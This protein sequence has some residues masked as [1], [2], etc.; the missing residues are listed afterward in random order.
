MFCYYLYNPKHVLKLLTII[1]RINLFLS[2]TILSTLAFSQ[3]GENDDVKIHYNLTVTDAYHHLAQ[4]DITFKGVMTKSFN[5]KLPNWRTGKYKILDLA[6]NI[7][8]FQAYDARN[9]P[10]KSAKIDKN[11]WKIFVNTPNIVKVSYQVYANQL[12]YRVS[13][14]D[15]THAFVDASGVFMYAPSLRDKSLTVELNVPKSWH[16]IS[17]LKRLGQHI[18][19][20]NNYD[21]LVDSPI[22]SGIHSY[23]SFKIGQQ[24]Y[25]IVIWGDGNYDRKR[26]I[27][28]IKKLHQQAQAI[29]YDFPFKRYVYIFHVGNKLR[30]ATEHINSTIIQTD[31]FAFSPDKKY[32]KIIGTT[33]HEFIHTWNVK[34]YRPAGISPYDYDKENYSDIFWLAEGTTS[35]YDNLINTRAGIYTLEQSLENLAEDI[36]KYQSKPG[37]KIMSLAESSFDT[38][39]DNN[40]NREHNTAVNIYLKGSL[41]SWLLDKEIRRLTNNNKSL[42]DLQLLLYQ[43]YASSPNGY[44][45]YDVLQLLKQITGYDFK[46]FWYDYVNSTKEINFDKLLDF[47]GLKFEKINKKEQQDEKNISLG[48]NIKEENNQLKISLV[49]TDSPAWLA[50][51]AYGDVLVAINTFAVSKENFD[52]I[53][54]SLRVG[55]SYIVHYFHQG[56]LMQ[57]QITPQKAKHIKRKIV[58]QKTANNK[59]KQRFLKWTGQQLDSL[60]N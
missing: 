2:L 58:A 9:K 56:K 3:N 42:D 37:R 12:N 49:E 36:F 19:Q 17:G 16:S 32:R 22:E 50:G 4:V 8:N 5:V 27:K 10:L 38:W 30:G 40:P 25:E 21:Q 45:S 46:Q 34:S 54:Q 43:K 23:D 55:D 24:S 59:Q 47:Y 60:K 52:S 29:W 7:R 14:I 20:A 13:H 53:L 39:L 48:L 51:L 35:Y 57:T 6:S 18:F 28:D 31:R 15:A 11:T 26:L 41:V 1:I 33:A 44:T